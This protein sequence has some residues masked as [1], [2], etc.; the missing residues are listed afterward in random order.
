MRVIWSPRY[1]LD[2]GP[3]VFPT[4]KYRLVKER[5]VAEGTIAAA[6]LVHPDPASPEDLL[7][8]HTE[9]YLRRIREDDFTPGER[10]LVFYLAGADPYRRDRLG[11]LGL[12]IE[13][14]RARDSRVLRSCRERG[15]GVAVVLAGGYAVDTADT[16]GIHCNTAREAA[17]AAR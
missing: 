4:R 12:T 6:D 17:S 16:V 5:L 13:G 15:A 8:V 1:E 7:R 2:I 9:E 10:Q 3:H 11:G 14:L